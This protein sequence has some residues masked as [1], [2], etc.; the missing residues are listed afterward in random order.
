MID[1]ASTNYLS[2]ISHSSISSTESSACSVEP[3]STEDVNVIVRYPDPT[4]QPLLTHIFTAA[5]PR[6]NSNALRGEGWRTRL[7]PGVFLD[8]RCT[9]CD[10]ALQ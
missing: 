4:H 2:D 5:Y 8:E 3:G 1:Q 9:D 10:V 6:I 7:E